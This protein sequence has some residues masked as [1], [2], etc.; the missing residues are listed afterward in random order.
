MRQGEPGGHLRGG[1]STPRL[2]RGCSMPR[3][4]GGRASI[5]GQLCPEPL[6]APTDLTGR[7]RALA[8]H[9]EGGSRTPGSCWQGS[10]PPPRPPGKTG[11]KVAPRLPI[12]HPR[13]DRWG[14]WVGCLPAWPVL[15]SLWL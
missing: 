8:A 1:A 10:G 2:G 3:R 5:D 6:R 11:S 12:P 4:V 7:T 15:L 9:W 13:G 14:L